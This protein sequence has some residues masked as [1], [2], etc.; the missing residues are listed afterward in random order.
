[1]SPRRR[2]ALPLALALALALAG[3]GSGSDGDGTDLTTRAPG[4]QRLA[5]TFG[6]R[7]SSEQ[8]LLGQLYKQALEAKGFRVALKQNIGSPQIA[9]TALHSGQI[10]LYPEYVGT[11]N[12]AVARDRTAYPSATAA[13]AAARRHARGRGYALLAP[14]P[15]TDVPALAVLPAFARAH[16]LRSVADLAAV[17]RLRIG[18]PPEFLRQRRGLV[19][20]ERVYGIR[21]VVFAPLTIGLQYRELDDGKIDVADVATTDGQLQGNRYVVLDD[22]RHLFGFQ[23]VTPVVSQRVLRE[24]GPAFAQTLDAVSG[25]LTTSAMQELNAAVGLDG[26]SPADVARQFLQAHGLA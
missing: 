4:A 1:M 10:D 24:T 3:C 21:D 23:Q 6:T 25:A 14:T 13:L 22:A 18:A 16:G 15:F 11:F 12:R 20:L 9:D 7:T 2:L 8:I 5:V 17:D 26:K 19:G